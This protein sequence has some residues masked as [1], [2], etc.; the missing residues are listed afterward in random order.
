MIISG[1]EFGKE[2][3]PLPETIVSRETICVVFDP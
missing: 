3:I 2:F 1:K